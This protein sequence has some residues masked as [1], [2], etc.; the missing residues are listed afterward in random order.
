MALAADGVPPDKL[1]PLDVDRAFRSLDRIKPHVRVWWTSGAQPA[2]LLTD[3]EVDMASAWNGRIYIIHKQGAKVETQWNEGVLMISGWVV[4]KGARNAKL[5]M[6][7]INFFLQVEPQVCYA[8]GMGYPGI[9]KKIFNLL[10]KEYARNLPT[11]P[12]NYK[13]Q[14]LA[15]YEWWVDNRDKVQ[16][17]WNAWMLK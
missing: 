16:E 9:N 14:I 1:Y 5:A 10:D 15:N 11:Y 6:E 12:E 7:L 2:Q 17:R 13:K 3:K 4:P 8:G